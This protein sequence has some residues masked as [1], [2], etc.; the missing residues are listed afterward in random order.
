MIPALVVCAPPPSSFATFLVVRAGVLTRCA[1]CLFVF[2]VV[3]LS[4]S[5]LCQPHGGDRRQIGPLPVPPP[6]PRAVSS[7]RPNPCAPFGAPCRG[8]YEAFPEVHASHVVPA[9][10]VVVPALPHG[11]PA[12]PV[13]PLPPL[14]PPHALTSHP[15]S[16]CPTIASSAR[17]CS[18]RSTILPSSTLPQ[19]LWVSRLRF[20]STTS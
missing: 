18:E 8:I 5:T 11:L 16:P 4:M 1:L 13:R 9:Q 12:P 14:A 6:P 10:A 2:Y 3:S 20:R 15:S 7:I 19:A 17:K